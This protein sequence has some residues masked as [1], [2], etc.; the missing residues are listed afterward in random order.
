MAHWR[1]GGIGNMAGSDDRPI[2]EWTLLEKL[3][4]LAADDSAGVH[5]CMQHPYGWGVALAAI[6]KEAF[7]EIQGLNALL[8][9]VTTRLNALSDV[10]EAE[11]K[12]AK[13]QR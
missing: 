4:A 1:D 12:R 5:P 11:I 2:E 7:D 8:D 3:A 13:E 9:T 6:A 10:I